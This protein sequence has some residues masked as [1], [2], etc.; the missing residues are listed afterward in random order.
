MPFLR[1]WRISENGSSCKNRFKAVFSDATPFAVLQ[2]T[3]SFF[4]AQEWVFLAAEISNNLEPRKSLHLPPLVEQGL[5]YV[6]NGW[7]FPLCP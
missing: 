4:H 7:G 2:S 1:F 6:L 3:T 5:N